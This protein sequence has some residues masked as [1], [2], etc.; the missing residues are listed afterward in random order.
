MQPPPG[1]ALVYII[2]SSV[3]GLAVGVRVSIN[4]YKIGLTRGRSF[5]YAILDPGTHIIRSMAENTSEIQLNVEAGKTYFIEQVI[6]MGV[7]I[8]RNKIILL[9]EEYGRQLLNKC[10]LHKSQIKF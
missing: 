3:L 10:K 7:L 4:D 1:K 8:A 2:R 6:K 5:L 9:D